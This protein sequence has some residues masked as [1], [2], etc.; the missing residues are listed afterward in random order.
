MSERNR[1]AIELRFAD[2]K[3]ITAWRSFTLT[4]NYLDPLDRF[5]FSVANV[6]EKERA[7]YIR[8]LAK[9]EEVT[10]WANG[11]QQAT[12]VILSQSGSITRQGGVEIE[13]QAV[14]TLHAAYQGSVDPYYSKNLT[15]DTPLADVVLEVLRP[16]GFSEINVDTAGNVAAVSGKP[17]AGQAAP[18]VLDDAKLKDFQGPQQGNTSAYA[19]CAA[20]FNRF[21]LVLRTDRKGKLLLGYPDFDQPAAYT[22]ESAR[23]SFFGGD[24]MM[25]VRW[26]DSNEGQFSHYVAR[27]ELADKPGATSASPP[28]AG[29]KTPGFVVPAGSPFE[30]ITYTELRDGR[31]NYRSEAHPYKPKFWLDKKARDQERCASMARSMAAVRGQSGFEV[32]GT[33]E[34]LISRSNRLWSIDTVGRVVV[35]ERELDENMWLVETTRTATRQGGQTTKL[36]WIPLYSLDLRST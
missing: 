32:T 6:D 27:G 9:G 22:A 33:V 21:G 35:S 34:G 5:T 18:V 13:I 25:D 1:A 30:S 11:S 15:V 10:L 12:C 36:K 31:Q 2:G 4:Q 3:P 19:W 24:V 14:S 29:V 17:L 28:I 7:S 23:G 26:K 16:Y 20:L 8:K